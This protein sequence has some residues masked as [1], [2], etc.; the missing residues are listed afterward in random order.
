M[1]VSSAGMANII[2]GQLG[3][4]RKTLSLSKQT[5]KQV[6]YCFN[7]ALSSEESAMSPPPLL[8]SNNYPTK[9]VGHSTTRLLMV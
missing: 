8:P 4:Y 3:L 2:S 1:S 9:K 7:T 5:N 6:K